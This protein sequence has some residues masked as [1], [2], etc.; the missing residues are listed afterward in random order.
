MK[1]FEFTEALD[2]VNEF[3]DQKGR[4]ET[5]LQMQGT[6]SNINIIYQNDIYKVYINNS[7]YI[8]DI[9]R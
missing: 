3:I 7:F 5:N 2:I 4:P 8:G 9:K 1:M 6:N